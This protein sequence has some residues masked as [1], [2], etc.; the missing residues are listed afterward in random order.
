MT[1]EHLSYGTSLNSRDDYNINVGLYGKSRGVNDRQRTTWQPRKF[2]SVEK[3]SYPC[4]LKMYQD[5]IEEGHGWS[6]KDHRNSTRAPIAR[7][8]NVQSVCNATC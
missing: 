8:A 2:T 3:M 1:D 4:Q 5:K 6:F 7:G